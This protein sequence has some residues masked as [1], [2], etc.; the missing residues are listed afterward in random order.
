VAGHDP[1]YKST[2]QYDPRAANALL[3]RF[4]YRKGTDGYRVLPDGKP[5]AIQYWSTPRERDRQIDELMKRSLD[6]IGVR[7][8]IHKERFA[9]LIKL[10]KQ[11]RVMMRGSAWIADYPDGDNFMQ[12]LYGPHTGQSNGACYRSPEFD[13]LY[14]KSKMLPD[15]AER[16]KLY[17]DMARLMEVH[18]VWR[19]WDSRYR[20]VLLQPRVIGYKKHPVTH[21]EWLY[22][23]LAAGKPN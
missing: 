6:A 18:T 1:D 9:E 19:L 22:M 10:D 15:G 12:L 2:I 11:C 17:H 4:G 8:E 16:N 13:R 20:N 23:D 14:S 3:D 5:F 21:V 7:I